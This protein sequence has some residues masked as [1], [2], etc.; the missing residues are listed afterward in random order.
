MVELSTNVIEIRE[1]HTQL[2]KEVVCASN[3]ELGRGALLNWIKFIKAHDTTLWLGFTTES[4]EYLGRV[5]I[6]NG[7]SS[8][9]IEA[10]HEAARDILNHIHG[11]AP[12]AAAEATEHL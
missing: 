3:T 12:A 5:Q 4:I 11:R 10:A 8:E 9:L 2:V 6:L 1:K 7:V